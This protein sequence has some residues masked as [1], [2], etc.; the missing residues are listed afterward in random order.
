MQWL[1]FFYSYYYANFVERPRQS[2]RQKQRPLYTRR[3]C[4]IISFFV[5][6]FFFFVLFL[7]YFSTIFSGEKKII[8]LR[9]FII[10]I[11]IYNKCAYMFIAPHTSHKCTETAVI[12]IRI[13]SEHSAANATKKK[14][15]STFWVTI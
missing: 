7:S 13:L 1:I 9:M 15:N 12:I 3:K 4:V 2:E 10:H 14:K 8:R 5:D 6:I 11:Y